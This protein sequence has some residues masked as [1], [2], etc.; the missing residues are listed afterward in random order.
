[1]CFIAADALL[2][3]RRRRKKASGEVKCNLSWNW[4]GAPTEKGEIGRKASESNGV[5]YTQKVG[6]TTQKTR[7]NRRT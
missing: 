4:L 3:W 7:W 5:C 1:M 6:R 2:M